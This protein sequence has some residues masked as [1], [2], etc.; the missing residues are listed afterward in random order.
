MLLGYGIQGRAQ[1]LNMRD[2]G[3]CVIIGQDKRFTKNWEQALEEFRQSDC[4]VYN[5]ISPSKDHW[6][7]AASG[8]SACHY[9]LIFGQKEIRVELVFASSNAKENKFIYDVLFKSRDEIEQ[10][11]GHKLEW[12]R[13]NDKKSS[14]IQFAREADGYNKELWPQWI[15]WMISEVSKLEKAFKAPLQDAANKMRSQGD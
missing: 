4:T 6:V 10:E 11:I 2:N 8:V 1:S 9:N 13:M 15:E 7:S 14:R 12:R 5:N 3:L